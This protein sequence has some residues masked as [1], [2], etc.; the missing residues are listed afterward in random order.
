MEII[1]P[2]ISAQRSLWALLN[3]AYI[4]CLQATFRGRLAQ[5]ATRAC[6]G[7]HRRY[8]LEAGMWLVG[9]IYNFVR[10]HSSL[11]EMR[12]PVIVARGMEGLLSYPVPPTKLPQCAG[13][14]RSGCWKQGK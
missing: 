11:G 8:T 2:V 12:T 4:E 6:A 7:A 10:V 3:T 9:A 14:S 5:L 1:S 13:G